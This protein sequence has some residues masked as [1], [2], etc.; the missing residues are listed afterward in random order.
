METRRS[1]M[2]AVIAFTSARVGLRSS[3]RSVSTTKG[4]ASC[5]AN[6]GVGMSCSMSGP[7][8]MLFVCNDFYASRLAR[9]LNR[10]TGVHFCGTRA[11]KKGGRFPASPL[12]PFLDSA[13][14]TGP[15][16]LHLV[17]RLLDRGFRHREYRHESA[18]AS[19][20]TK[21]D[22]TFDLGE[23]GMVRAHADIKAGMPRGA[24]LARDDVTGNHVLA[25]VGLDSEPLARRITPVTR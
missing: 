7:R 11:R 20:C 22:M 2:R 13:G 24:A 15:G 10:K 8:V 23:Q 16:G 12:E 3:S 5:N 19:F 17:H 14:S 9:V 25:A 6:V 1:L 18:A 4:L 21:L